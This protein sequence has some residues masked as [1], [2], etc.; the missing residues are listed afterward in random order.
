MGAGL[1]VVAVIAKLIMMY[2]EAK[3]PERIARRAREQELEQAKLE[4]MS[5]EKWEAIQAMRPRT[6]FE[7]RA[8][9]DGAR[10]RTGETIT[11]EDFRDWAVDVL[12][13]KLCGR[14]EA[15]RK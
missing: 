7:S 6:P 8:G 12:V 5:R 4:P 10:L 2:D 11:L 3:E 9:R 15:V 14:E 13:D 1:A